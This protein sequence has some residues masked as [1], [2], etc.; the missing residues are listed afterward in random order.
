MIYSIIKTGGAYTGQSVFKGSY[1]A[2]TIWLG[3]KTEL[4]PA[5]SIVRLINGLKILS[6]DKT[7]QFIYQI[8]PGGSN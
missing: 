6:G 7:T 5:W 2:C 3:V 8:K 4:C 1:K